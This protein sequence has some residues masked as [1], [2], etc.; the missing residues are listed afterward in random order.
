MSDSRFLDTRVDI[1][2]DDGVVT[3][4]GEVGSPDKR[5]AMIDAIS[6][7]VGVRRVVADELLVT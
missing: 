6:Q 5:I 1:R 4:S 3:L 7:V 2:T